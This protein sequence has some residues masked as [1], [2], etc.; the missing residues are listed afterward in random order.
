MQ[1]CETF[2]T[3]L[4]SLM[5]FS[6]LGRW[7]R[8]SYVASKDDCSVPQCDIKQERVVAFHSEQFRFNPRFMGTRRA[9]H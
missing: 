7:G 9:Q 4:L 8:S 3:I 5:L 6:K 2:A 1:Y